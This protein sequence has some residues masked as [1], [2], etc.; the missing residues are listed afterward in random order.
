MLDSNLPTTTYHRP[1]P[2]DPNNRYS[3]QPSH[4]LWP[5]HVLATLPPTL[6]IYQTTSCTTSASAS[7]AAAPPLAIPVPT[8]TPAAAAMDDLRDH[9][10]QLEA[11]ANLATAIEDVQKVIDQ[12]TAARAKIAA[13]DSA[14]VVLAKLQDPVKKTLDTA[15]KDLKPIYAGLNKYAKALDKVRPHIPFGH[16]HL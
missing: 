6:K 7:A 14:P 9:I 1:N 5:C 16:V 10:D 13:G 11:S 15:Q 12:L 3:P 8:P 4:G 2:L